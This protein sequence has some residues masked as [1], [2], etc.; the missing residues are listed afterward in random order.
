MTDSPGFVD[1]RILP[2]DIGVQNRQEASVGVTSIPPVVVIWQPISIT[3]WPIAGSSQSRI[4][5]VG[6]CYQELFWEGWAE[7]LNDRGTIRS[8]RN[9]EMHEILS[10]FEHIS[11]HLLM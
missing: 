2:I 9:L 11:D 3:R 10:S 1:S 7:S 6:S 5:M 4:L 8:A